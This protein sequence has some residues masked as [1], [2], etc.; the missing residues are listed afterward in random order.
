MFVKVQP[1][2]N[3]CC[4]FSTIPC[5]VV[6][7]AVAFGQWPKLVLK[8]IEQRIHLYMD[9]SIADAG[10]TETNNPSGTPIRITCKLIYKNKKNHPSFIDYVINRWHKS[11]CSTTS[12]NGQT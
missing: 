10:I 9:G 7:S 12:V 6:T 3:I 11:Q 8:Y 5:T 4:N 2:M 1:D